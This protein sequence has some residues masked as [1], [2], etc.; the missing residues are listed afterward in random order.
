MIGYFLVMAVG[1]AMIFYSGFMGNA[2]VNKGQE[3]TV[4]YV[5]SKIVSAIIFILGS[6]LT[7]SAITHAILDF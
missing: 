7:I 4:A 6:G 2:P 3:K 5:T 1:I